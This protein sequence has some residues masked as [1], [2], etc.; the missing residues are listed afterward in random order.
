VA[1]AGH[2]VAL[3]RRSL[4]DEIECFGYHAFLRGCI[5]M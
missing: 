1:G 5:S 2:K 4:L 3:C